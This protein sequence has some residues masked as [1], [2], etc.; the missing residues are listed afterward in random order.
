MEELHIISNPEEPH[1]LKKMFVSDTI[2]KLLKEKGFDE[3]C[4]A[5]YLLSYTTDEYKFYMVGE[6]SQTG[7]IDWYTN[8]V[9]VGLTNAEMQRN[10]IGRLKQ[11]FT[12]PIY[13]HVIKWFREKQGLDIQITNETLYSYC[14][15]ISA[16]QHDLR[17]GTF[18]LGKEYDSIRTQFTIEEEELAFSKAIEEALKYIG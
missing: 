18:C 9:G 8:Y 17:D 12:A 6:R 3:P 1:P 4:F 7:N 15:K 11:C 13:S 2:A 14:I 5:Y 16:I 10:P